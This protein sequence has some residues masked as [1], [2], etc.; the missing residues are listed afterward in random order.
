MATDGDQTTWTEDWRT[1]MTD[2][3]WTWMNQ[4]W[5]HCTTRL[6]TLDRRHKQYYLY[7][8]SQSRKRDL[9]I[10]EQ[11]AHPF[12]RDSP[13]PRSSST[14]SRVVLVMVDEMTDQRLFSLMEPLGPI[15]LYI[16]W[17]CALQEE[18]LESNAFSLSMK[19]CCRCV[20][21]ASRELQNRHHSYWLL[22]LL[23][24]IFYFP[25]LSYYKLYSFEVTIGPSF[26]F[27][28]S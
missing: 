28:L 17:C 27:V 20:M 23:V 12:L 16:L 9:I 7:L 22:C 25:F 1:F 26:F 5:Q 24:A 4:S 11:R 10:A 18:P 21:S 2:D 19:R 15:F 6:L 3:G 8:G 13:A 14:G